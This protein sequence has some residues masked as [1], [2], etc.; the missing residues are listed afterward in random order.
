MEEHQQ[1]P[2]G[3]GYRYNHP[4]TGEKMVEYHVDTHDSFQEKMADETWLGGRRSVRYPTGK[5]LIILGH[6][7]MIIKQFLLTKKGWTGPNGQISLIPK[8]D[9]ISM[10]ISAFQS[11]KFGFGNK[12]NEYRIGEKYKDEKAA[13][14]KRGSLFKKPLTVSDNPFVYYFNYGAQEEGYWCYNMMVLQLE[15]VIDCLTILHPEFDYLFL[16]DHSCG[17]DHQREDGLNAGRMLKLFGGKQPRMRATKIKKREGYLGTYQA[18]V[19][20]G[21]VQQMVFSPTDTG[22]CWMLPEER[23]AKRKDKIL[24][25]TKVQNF[26]KKRTARKA[27]GK[28]YHLQRKHGRFETSCS[29][30]W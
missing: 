11:R 19:T 1:L 26:T 29:K 6:D 15:D 2:T 10:M 17:H 4:L 28:E 30:F 23:E 13:M 5:L 14:E 20:V 18:S 21:D 27:Q 25:T 9:G 16:F 12:V 7:E 24:S 3:A 22:P 8:D